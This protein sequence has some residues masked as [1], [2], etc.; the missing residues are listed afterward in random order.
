MDAGRDAR[1]AD[2]KAKSLREQAKRQYTGHVQT[3]TELRQ[4]ALDQ[5]QKWKLVPPGAGT[6]EA[7]NP[8]DPLPVVGQY[9]ATGANWSRGSR[10]FCGRDF[11]S[12]IGCSGP[13]SFFGRC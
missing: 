10:V 8:A 12:R 2:K 13:H 1:G 9:V 4:E 11:W 7:E 5:L 3:A 6:I